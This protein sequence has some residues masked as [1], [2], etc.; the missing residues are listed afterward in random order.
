[1]KKIA[2]LFMVTGLVGCNEYSI[3]ESGRNTFLLNQKN[4]K[5]SIIENG[6]IIGLPKYDL[7]KEI[8]LTVNGS[9]RSLIDFNVETKQITD[10]VLYRLELEG[11]KFKVKGEEGTYTTKSRD[12]AWYPNVVKD[13]NYDGITLQFRDSDGFT[14]I[15]HKVSVNS[16]YT[17]VVDH[18]GNI[19]GM[20]IEGQFTVDPILASRV[21]SLGY[22]YQ[23]KAVE[24]YAVEQEP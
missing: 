13:Y 12:F 3:Q 23:M 20:S 8:K 4:G 5:V 24:A 10:K 9:F 15:E 22:L 19:T 6:K 16:N 2:V 11:H 21:T 17:R 1:M 18:E 14:L 7:A